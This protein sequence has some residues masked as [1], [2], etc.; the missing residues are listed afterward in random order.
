MLKG[1]GEEKKV[2]SV[3][4]FTCST[5]SQSQSKCGTKSLLQIPQIQSNHVPDYIMTYF[6]ESQNGAENHS[7]KYSLTC[8]KRSALLGNSSLTV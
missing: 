6:L 4:C 2:S 8:I 1:K 7:V 5:W 3:K